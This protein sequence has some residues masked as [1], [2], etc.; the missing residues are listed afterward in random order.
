MAGR[1]IHERDSA[2]GDWPLCTF[3]IYHVVEHHN[4]YSFLASRH[5]CAVGVCCMG[6]R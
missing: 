2:E 1:L 5:V 6:D 3:T 4:A